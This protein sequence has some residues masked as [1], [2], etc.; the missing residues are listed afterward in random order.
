MS[1]NNDEKKTT[2]SIFDEPSEP[3]E[4]G[5]NVIDEAGDSESGPIKKSVSDAGHLRMNVDAG[6]ID[7]YD[8]GPEAAAV[9]KKKEEEGTAPPDMPETE[10][11]PVNNPAMLS[12]PADRLRDEMELRFTQ[13]FG[14]LT[15]KVT[16]ADRE[17]FVRA[18]LHDSELVFRI[19]I[20]GVNA[21][22]DIAMPP[23]EFT[24]SAAAAVTH[25]SNEDFIDK[26]SDLQWLLAFQQIH[27]WYQVR[28]IDG[29]PTP[30]S[31]Y[32]VDG[33]PP[34][35]TMRAA[36]RDTSNFEPFFKMS[37]VRWRMLIEAVRMA[38]LKYK[39]C[40]QNWRDRSFFTG[41]D[42]V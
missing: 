39:I 19:P 28:A 9:R 21:I 37:A 22:I 15:I 30:W 25:W 11:I 33:M 14:S 1:E 24:N 26:S 2:R 34:I 8:H 27:A 20:E 41:A 38:E 17:A 4:E 23:D 13:E 35:K 32:W 31:D 29:E 18:A 5:A 6:D 36:M 10:D 12:S 7:P 42:T 40:Q 3:K 16:S